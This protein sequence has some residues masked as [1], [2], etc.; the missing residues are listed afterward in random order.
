MPMRPEDGIPDDNGKRCQGPTVQRA[1]AAAHNTRS[2]PLAVEAVNWADRS[3]KWAA[4]A[5]AARLPFRR[6]DRIFLH[7]GIP[8]RIFCKSYAVLLSGL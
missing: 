4:A 2:A 6:P 7:P 8:L 1:G 3:V 5:A